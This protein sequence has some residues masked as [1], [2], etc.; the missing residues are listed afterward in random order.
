MVPDPTSTQ[1]L[2]DDLVSSGRCLIAVLELQVT[3]AM[4]GAA[5]A[6]PESAARKS[7]QQSQRH[8]AACEERYRVA[9]ANWRN[10]IPAKSAG[11]VRSGHF[12]NSR[13]AS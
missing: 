2:W 7:W 4:E 5:S 11:A 9:L 10:A 6:E 3:L 8:A 13:L 1:Q 12:R